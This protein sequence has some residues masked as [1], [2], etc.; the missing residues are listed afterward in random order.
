MRWM[1]GTTESIRYHRK[2]PISRRLTVCRF[3]V[4]HF[5]E[6]RFSRLAPLVVVPAGDM[7][8]GL[9]SAPIT[10][11]DYSF[12]GCVDI[13]GDLDGDAETVGCLNADPSICVGDATNGTITLTQTGCTPTYVLDDS[14][15]TCP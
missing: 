5:Y 1:W 3:S 12:L 13:D 6:S 14:C 11:P 9:V 15:P 7:L 8:F 2:G 4:V 10:L